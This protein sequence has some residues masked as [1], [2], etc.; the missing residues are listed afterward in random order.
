MINQIYKQYNSL[1]DDE[2][3]YLKLNPHHSFA[4]KKAR[5]VAF[6]TTKSRFGRNGHNDKS[7]AF[8]HCFWSA[9]LARDIGYK[10][11]LKFT[12]AHEDF[13]ENPANE[14]DMDL[15]NNKVG[16]R[17]GLSMASNDKLAH[18]C[19]TSLLVGRLKVIKRDDKK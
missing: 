10:N 3:E 9:M 2:K 4:I 11:A 6:S 12:T 13:P 16:I 18:Y 15:H 1:K 17:L 5:D 8:R 7:D 14:K 19:H